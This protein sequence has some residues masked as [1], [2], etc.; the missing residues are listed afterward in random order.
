[1]CFIL[2][3]L[4]SFLLLSFF[5]RYF[6]FLL[7]KRR[8]MKFVLNR[9]VSFFF[10]FLFVRLFNF[11]KKFFFIKVT[12]VAYIYKHL[13]PRISMKTRINTGI[14]DR[15]HSSCIRIT[16]RKST[17]RRRRKKNNGPNPSAIRN[18]RLAARCSYFIGMGV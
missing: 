13:I 14:I 16:T 11:V 5:F 18:E 15:I 7:P 17:R 8:G 9:I 12:Q 1:M 10:S 3:R 6:E 2:N 4:I